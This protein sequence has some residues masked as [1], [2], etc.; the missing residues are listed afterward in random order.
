VHHRHLSDLVLS[1]LFQTPPA[2]PPLPATFHFLLDSRF[3]SRL[4]TSNASLPS[5]VPYYCPL[6]LENRA[7]APAHLERIITEI[8]CLHL[9]PP[10]PPTLCLMYV[11][12]VGSLSTYIYRPTLNMSVQEYP[13]ASDILQDSGF[14]ED[15][16]VR[17]QSAF[18][19]CC[20]EHYPD[21]FTRVINNDGFLLF[22]FQAIA[23]AHSDA[24]AESNAVCRRHASGPHPEGGH[25]ENNWFHASNPHNS[26]FAQGNTLFL[27]S[28]SDR[29]EHVMKVIANVDQQLPEDT[30][31]SDSHYQSQAQ[32]QQHTQPPPSPSESY[33]TNMASN[34]NP[35]IQL[36][37][38]QQHFSLAQAQILNPQCPGRS[39]GNRTS[40]SGESSGAQSDNSLA[41][42][43]KLGGKRAP[44]RYY[45]TVEDCPK[46]DEPMQ[47]CRLE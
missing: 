16:F 18:V 26:H 4:S 44:G 6:A 47:K 19:A 5:L 28:P 10:P 14:V 23:A 36:M 17:F 21:R 12:S 35:Q 2:R 32:Q 31:M 39:I 38:T 7:P 11:R 13:E 46:K 24:R 27:S 41:S 37:G 34:G 8:I 30:I 9:Y 3:C 29:E 43:R 15:L 25:F 40:E 42:A 20:T 33:Q 45:C 1:V 22:I